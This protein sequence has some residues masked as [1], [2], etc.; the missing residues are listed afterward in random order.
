MN[1]RKF[2]HH[3]LKMGMAPIALSG[4][5]LKGITAS[6]MPAN[7]C[8]INDRSVV[9]VYLN[10]GN[11]IFNTM[12]PLNHYDTYV[13]K[14]PFIHLNQ[15]QLLTLD[16]T[17]GNDQQL[18]LHPNLT[19][20][21]SLYDSGK[22]SII[23]GV[24]Y[25]IPN[26]SH[27][28]SLDIMLR[29]VGDTTE[30]TEGWIGRYFK[31][32]FPNYAGAP[33]T[34]EP[35]PLGLLFGNINN[36]GFHTE[37]EHAWEINLSEVDPGGFY[38]L[39]SSLSGQPIFNFPN[40]EYGDMLRF[41][42]EVEY[43][44]NFYSSRLSSVSQNGTNSIS[45]P[46]NPLSSQLQTVARLLSGGSR[47]KVFMV[48]HVGY[49][50]HGSQ[51]GTHA[52]LL[53][54]LSETLNTFQTDLNNQGIANNVLTIVF[55]EF[56]RKIIQNGALGTD[57]GTLSSMFV[58]GSNV[59]PGVIGSNIDLTKEDHL[60]APDAAGL[61]YDYRK[62]LATVLQDWLGASTNSI[63]NTFLTNSFL[64]NKPQ[65][66]STNAAADPSCYLQAAPPTLTP[67]GGD[68]PNVYSYI[69][70][71]GNCVQVDC[72]EGVPNVESSL[73]LDE[74]AY[75]TPVDVPKIYARDSIQANGD[76]RNIVTSEL[77]VK[78]G[79]KIRLSNNFH[80]KGRAFRLRIR[81]CDQ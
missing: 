56:G 64:K 22:V 67:C 81:D 20:F 37:Q 6:M 60:G 69:D 40:S 30:D 73:V 49:D 17:L 75:L 7:T 21:K 66:I 13:N 71:N 26:R 46:S 61:A 27:F 42:T 10:G 41:L 63:T 31:D 48:Q 72:L 51:L 79:K 18:G 68:E 80:S 38:E 65:I 3:S 43:G 78:A 32:R 74:N 28:A 50:T 24:G 62:V 34:L 16:N 45:Y 29:G 57:H 35:D 70:E 33:T 4:L 25:P 9:I 53:N 58:I 2:L 44:S 15:N 8:D 36:S 11:D 19:A 47:T 39:I 52:S 5:P 76:L 14:R 1:R 55:S 54:D 59:N 23:Q 12:V 77:E